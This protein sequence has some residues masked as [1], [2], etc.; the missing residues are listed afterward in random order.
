MR[1]FAQCIRLL[2][3]HNLLCASIYFPACWYGAVYSY[4][5]AVINVAKVNHSVPFFKQEQF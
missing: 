5:I 3:P 4:K 1:E 2:M